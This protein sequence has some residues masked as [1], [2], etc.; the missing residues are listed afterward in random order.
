LA[1]TIFASVFFAAVFSKKPRPRQRYLE[2]WQLGAVSV[3]IALLTALLA[4]PRPIEPVDLPMPRVDRREQR[5]AAERERALAAH[6]VEQSLPFDVRVVGERLRRLGD[7]EARGE[8]RD[9]DHDE[10]REAVAALRADDQDA[11]HGLLAVQCE[12]FLEALARWDATGNTSRTLD[13]L[14]GSFARRAR[15]V[16]LW[17]GR[18]RL[19]SAERRLVFRLRWLKLAGRLDAARFAPSLN[20]WRAYYRLLLEEPAFFGETS[21]RDAIARLQRLD[22]RYPADFALGVIAFKRGNYAAAANLFDDH[23]ERNGPWS[24][25]ARHHRRA[26][27]EGA[28][29]EP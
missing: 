4:V 14:G 28:P 11:L 3:G 9:A 10:L 22:A 2:G 20:D 26:A 13:E 7:A 5:L 17:N 16:G 12:L 24:L 15:A 19:T 1:A 29:P 25:R 8:A 21:E 18:L 23:L 27:L 6:W